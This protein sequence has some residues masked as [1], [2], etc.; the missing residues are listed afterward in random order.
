MLAS[1]G[2]LKR[3]VSLMEFKTE[4]ARRPFVP[5]EQVQPASIDL[6]LDRVFWF[7][8][9]PR[10]RRKID[11]RTPLK[12][13]REI[14]T[15][16]ERRTFKPGEA[17]TLPPGRMVMGRIYEAFQV[18]HDYAAVIKGKSSFARLGLSIFCT[19]DF[20]NPG[21]QGH[22]P[23]QI[24]NHNTVPILLPPYV[25]ICQLLL[26]KLTAPCAKPYGSPGLDNKY[27][28]DEG[29]P[30]KIW[31][32]KRLQKLQES[33]GRVNLPA[34]AREDFKKVMGDA[35]TEM[36]GRFHGFLDDLPAGEHT[37]S[38]EILERFAGREFLCGKMDTIR[39]RVLRVARVR[40]GADELRHP[41]QGAV[42]HATL[43]PMGGYRAVRRRRL[44]L[45]FLGRS[46]GQTIH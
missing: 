8:R 29:A 22:M 26:V 1:D 39:H 14:E 27:M 31:E 10:G 9:T 6:R 21:W 32:D 38:R 12:D 15:L 11:L 41:F 19:G 45:R 30:S 4:D 37:N 23:L 44:L 42:R 20:I 2:D 7:P 24:V 5:D 17:I 34:K 18:P 46:A 25:G 40:V 35:D 28:N 43:R 3:L 13:N 36:L 33:I 16:F